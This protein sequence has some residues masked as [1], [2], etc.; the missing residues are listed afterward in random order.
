MGN[1]NNTFY[2][3][4]FLDHYGKAKCIAGYII[5]KYN[6]NIFLEKIIIDANG[7]ILPNKKKLLT[8]SIR[9]G[10]IIN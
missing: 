1:E 7:M 2:P 10:K 5:K 9:P 6:D 4:K 8:C 3:K